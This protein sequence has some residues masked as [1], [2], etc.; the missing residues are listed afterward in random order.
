MKKAI[1]YILPVGYAVLGT[2]VAWCTL[3]FSS[4]LMSIATAGVNKATALILLFGAVVS[5]VG[6]VALLI[7]NYSII[8]YSLAPKLTVAVELLECA[9]LFIPLMALWKKVFDSISISLYT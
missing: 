7:Y 8:D 4:I 5:V 2:F 9:L 1:L 6:M 3:S